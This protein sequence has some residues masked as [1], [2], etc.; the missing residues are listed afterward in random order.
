MSCAQKS[1]KVDIGEVQ[2]QQ[3]EVV[4]EFEKANRL[5][6]GNQPAEAAALYDAL[7]VKY[8]GN[9]LDTVIIFN[10]GIAYLESKQCEL[11]GERLRKVMR[12]T[13]R[14][15]SAIRARA[16]LKMSDVYTCLGEDNK[17]ITNLIEIFL[18]KHDLPVEILKAEVPAKL[19]AAYARIGNNKEAE[20][21]FKI[22][23]RG[24]QQVQLTYTG[25][26]QKIEALA[27]TLFLMGNISQISVL[28]MSGD[29]YFATIR[30]L[31]K[32]LYKSVELNDS[33]WSPQSSK[34]IIFAYE[35]VWDYINRVRVSE[36]SDPE[37]ARRDMKIEQLR[38]AQTALTSILKLYDERIPDPNESALITELF[39][40][41]KTSEI[42]IRN[43]IATNIVGT[44]LT[45]QALEVE[46]LKRA[47]R[48]LNPDPILE[49]KAL[50]RKNKKSK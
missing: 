44:D 48:V 16:T 35:N 27:K 49:R 36:E 19:A 9:Q 37:I 14:K 23:E 1:K 47:G 15:F 33:T 8:P 41:M 42:K 24:L 32:Y 31:Q 20:K 11:A 21:Y 25:K 26:K 45:T 22:A 34:Q 30:A 4:S 2:S 10:S 38:I 5:L 40:K 46:G 3:D 28:T 6:D 17:A 29:D 50:K 7:I 39:K 13:T 12:M 43:F 18:G